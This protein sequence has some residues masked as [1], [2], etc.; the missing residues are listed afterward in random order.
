M[1]HDRKDQLIDLGYSDLKNYN[2]DY[3]NLFPEN[4]FTY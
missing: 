1:F 3:Y 4:H 2:I